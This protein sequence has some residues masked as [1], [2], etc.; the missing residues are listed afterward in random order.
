MVVA[1]KCC[2]LALALGEDQGSSIDVCTVGGDRGIEVVKMI[3]KVLRA[4]GE[5]AFGV[6]TED[7]WRSPVLGEGVRAIAV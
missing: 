3:A 6:S 7:E 4:N 5:G 1:I 2:P